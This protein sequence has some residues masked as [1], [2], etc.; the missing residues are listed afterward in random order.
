MGFLVLK[1][2]VVVERLPKPRPGKILRRSMRRLAD[3][4][5]YTTP[6]TIDDQSSCTK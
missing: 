1:A 6:A 3:S 5:D 4:E 2:A